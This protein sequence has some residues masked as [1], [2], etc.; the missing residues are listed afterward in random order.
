[1]KRTCVSTIYMNALTSAAFKFAEARVDSC[2]T[3]Y[4]KKVFNS[5]YDVYRNIGLY[6]YIQLYTQSYNA[7]DFKFNHLF[8][9][10]LKKFSARFYKKVLLDMEKQKLIVINNH[11][12]NAKDKKTSFTKSYLIHRDVMKKMDDAKEKLIYQ[13]VEIDVP[14]KVEKV[15]CKEKVSKPEEVKEAR[16]I[17]TRFNE[18]QQNESDSRCLE[19]YERLDYDEKAL[20]EYCGN[21]DLKFDK[22][23]SKL[24]R[25][26]VNA[27]FI[28]GRFYHVFHELPKDLREEVL[29]CDN[30]HIKEVFDVSASD[31]HMLAKHLESIEEIPDSELLKF[32][33]AVKSDLR[34]EI[35]KLHSTHPN[36]DRVKTAFKVY[37][38]GDK[39][40]FN[41]LSSTSLLGTIDLYFQANFPHIREYIKKT[42]NIWEIC[43]NEEFKVM[44]E[45]LVEEL[46]KEGVVSFTCH[47]AIYVKQS[48]VKKVRDIKERFYKALDFKNDRY[49]SL[50][51]L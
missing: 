27:K 25:L 26:N 5:A 30:E 32:Q 35:S 19:F 16:T 40:Q 49:E 17:L 3:K 34:E 47:D 21:D 24:Y 11:Y 10:D 45:D 12:L 44:S 33:A 29:R 1:M 8:C 9:L 46:F 37:L 23:Q 38:N 4:K 15:L 6:M 39:R 43:M 7:R 51:N 50:F 31:L 41:W 48:D 36:R 18:Q 2:N 20:R 42:E 28:K 13:T 22:F 14:E